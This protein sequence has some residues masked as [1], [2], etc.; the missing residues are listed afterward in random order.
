MQFCWSPSDARP[1]IIQIHLM[2]K[3]LLQIHQ[4]SKNAIN[5]QPSDL[6][7]DFD[8]RWKSFKPNSIKRT[9]NHEFAVNGVDLTD[10]TVSTDNREECLLTTKSMS[11]SLNNL[12]G[13]LD[14]LTGEKMDS[15]L[16]K[17]A[18]KTGD[19]SYVRGLCEVIKDLDNTLAL[20]NV[21]S[22]DSSPLLEKDPETKTL[23]FKL[24]PTEDFNKIEISSESETEDENWRK[25]IELGVYSEKVHQ[26]SKSVTDLMV[27]T[28]IDC[29]ESDSETPLPSLD[30]RV[31][32]R[33]VRYAPKQNL[34]AVSLTF[35]SEGNLLSIHD[36][37]Q[38]ELKKLQE[39]RRDS[40]LF[41][42][43]RNSQ[44]DNSIF[45]NDDT[46][47][48]VNNRELENLTSSKYFKFIV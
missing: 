8:T 39:E 38:Q 32:Y 26:K 3:N 14:N 23:D 29:S 34:E 42:P 31:N 48:Y 11:P 13:S 36:K 47:K 19:M 27:L 44:V 6:M 24:G 7:E 30:Y 21:S 43:D 20:E 33:N 35:G 40:L 45:N 9:D 1:S 46:C 15:W 28:H 37:F 25:K 18:N 5:S 22:S 17:V 4:D 2:L 41:V 10:I 12:H 16:Q